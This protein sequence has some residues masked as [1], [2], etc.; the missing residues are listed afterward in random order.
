MPQPSA[1]IEARSV[2]TKFGDVVVHR[3][4]SFSISEPSVVALIGGSGCGKS[5]LLREIV[6]LLRPTGGKTF[7]FGTDIWGADQAALHAVRMRFG[8]LFQ[9]GALFSA[10]NVCDN[11]A[12]PLRE[13]SDLPESLVEEMV[14]L[15]LGLSGLP[16]GTAMKMPSELSG[17]MR[18]RVAL[19][20]ALALEPE[21]LFLDEPTSGLD[22]I[23][24]RGFDQLVRTLCDSLGITV[25]LVTHDLDTLWGI[26]DRVIVLGEGRVLADG[27]ISEVAQFKHDWV[28]AYFS[29]RVKKG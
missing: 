4:V 26:V 27:S 18:K 5:V 17:G 22:P 25:V 9:N 28:Q 2:E 21:V 24:A 10:L 7:L 3:D 29:A 16:E 14:C 15:R 19:A 20:R 1:I 13:Q 6:G 11:V 23:N 12:V 8:V